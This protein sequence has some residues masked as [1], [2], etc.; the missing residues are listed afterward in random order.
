MPI[1][2][3]ISLDD[4]LKF[5]FTNPESTINYL[6]YITQPINHSIIVQNLLMLGHEDAVKKFLEKNTP[7]NY[8][9]IFMECNIGL[10]PFDNIFVNADLTFSFQDFL[11]DES[12]PIYKRKTKLNNLVNNFKGILKYISIQ[13]DIEVIKKLEKNEVSELVKLFRN[14]FSSEDFIITKTSTYF[15]L[16]KYSTKFP[17]FLNNLILYCIGYRFIMFYSKLLNDFS[18]LLD[19]SNHEQ[20]MSESKTLTIIKKQLN[21][22]ETQ[23]ERI[24]NP[25]PRIFLNNDAFLLFE[26]LKNKLCT[27]E[28][29]LLADFSFVFRL[30]QKESYI[31]DDISE[32]S[33][34]NFLTNNYEITFDKLKTYEYCVTDKKIQLYNSLKK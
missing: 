19:N 30:M 6:I 7:I 28:K 20:L 23:E 10:I 34:R 18:I 12:I 32:G 27:N 1:P 14:K 8:N 4:N 13:T 31:F 29:S 9:M 5:D 2:K 33:F 25:H 24:E 21:I 17:V 16:S 26:E 22:D 11:F 15:A 3:T